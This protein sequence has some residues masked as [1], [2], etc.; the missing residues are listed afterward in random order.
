MNRGHKLMVRPECGV[1]L[2]GLCLRNFEKLHKQ[3][4]LEGECMAGIQ[5]R[6]LMNAMQ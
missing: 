4:V 3:M 1:R 6:S 5:C 2:G